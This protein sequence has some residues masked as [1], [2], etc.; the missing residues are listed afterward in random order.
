MKKRSGLLLSLFIAFA[1][2]SQNTKTD[3]AIIPEPVNVVKNAGV[4]VLPKAITIEAGSQ[5]ELR[6][7]IVFLKNH[8]S[9]PTGFSVSVSSS[10]PAA[11]V[12]L[13]LNRSQNAEIGKEGYQL[14]VAPKQVT[15]SANQPAGLFYGVQSLV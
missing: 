4:F 14:S 6:Q 3:I 15:I 2:F 9:V 10:A 7:A 1:S 5:P 13:V 12:R 11:T 8:L